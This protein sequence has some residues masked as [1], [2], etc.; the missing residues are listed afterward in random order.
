M[1]AKK[2]KRPIAT[3]DCETDPFSKGRVPRPFVW[4]LYRGDTEDYWQFDTAA[5]VAE[6]LSDKEWIVYAHNGGK[7]DYH[8][9]REYFNSDEPFMVISGRIAKFRIGVCEFRDSI[10][11]L[12]VSLETFE[13]QKI[14]YSL[15]EPGER[16]KPHNR[17]LIE[18]YLQS[19]CTNL[20]TF[21]RAFIDQYGLHLTQAGA[22]MKY[23]SKTFGRDI[24]HQSDHHYKL[25]KPYYYGGRVQC[26]ASGH[27]RMPFQVIDINSAYPYAML[28][29][30]PYSSG[31]MTKLGLPKGDKLGPQLVRLRA[32]SKG[33]LPLRD[34]K[35][36][37]YFPEDERKAREYFA[38]GWEVKA[39]LETDTLKVTRVLEC[40]VFDQTVNFKEYVEHFYTM[41]KTAKAA[42][43]KA[44]DIFAKIFL[45]SLYGKFASN[46][47]KY[48][49]QVISSD[50]AEKRAEHNAAGFITS[51]MWDERR[52]LMQRPLPVAKRRHYNIATSAS[53]TGFVRAH[54]WRSLVQ[55]SGALY[56][57]TDSIAAADVGKLPLGNELGQWKLE[58]QC[59]EYAI[60][61]KKLYAFH[62]RGEPRAP[63]YGQDGKKR[64]PWKTA[65]K[66]V[67]LSADE[68]IAVAQKQTVE[69]SPQ[70]PTYSIHKPEPAFTPRIVKTTYRDIRNYER[71]KTA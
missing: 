37:L 19:D 20:Y 45:N 27:G 67:D 56:C 6:F 2:D 17:R 70:V 53:I 33:A 54:L 57:D 14:D 69:Y 12:P 39:G 44:T 24:P 30:H 8:Y 60:A 58:M 26:F 9:L 1:P 64:D 3:L 49:E 50:D 43:D 36:E 40:H 32:V 65:S 51:G 15:F 48:A 28:S 31:Y 62:E 23:W 25:L 68:I 16:D 46:P 47:D 55:C 11:L 29:E 13:K 35:G 41:R 10:N 21:V 66:G 63:Y 5:D 22:A 61:G 34:E 59:D 7:F 71:R 42:G 18:L 52:E 4:G 38:T